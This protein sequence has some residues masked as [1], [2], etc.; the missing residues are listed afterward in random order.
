[1]PDS[2][3]PEDALQKLQEGNARFVTGRREH[4]H[5]FLTRA[6]ETAQTGQKPVAVIL[7]CSDSRVPLEIIFD[8]GLGDIFAIRVAGNVCRPSELGSIEFAVTTTGTRLC[9]ILGH[10]KCGAVTAACR[11]ETHNDNIDVILD[12]IEPAVRRTAAHHHE[13]QHNSETPD[14]TEF[15]NDCCVENVF[16]QMESLFRQSHVVRD[17]VRAGELLVVGAIY[18]IEIGL[19]TFLDLHSHIGSA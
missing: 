10:T 4:P 14:D 2:I 8:Q 19:V 7:S 11:H 16:V 9:V 3:S 5:E 18:D 12:A 13:H 1:M 6:Y 17:A 15:I